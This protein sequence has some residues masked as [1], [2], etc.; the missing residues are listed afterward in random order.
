VGTPK[1]CSDVPAR[2]GRSMAC[3]QISLRVVLRLLTTDTI[4]YPLHL[5]NTLLHP[6][7]I[8]TSGRVTADAIRLRSL[9]TLPLV[10]DFLFCVGVGVGWY[11]VGSNHVANSFCQAEAGT[12]S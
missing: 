10:L 4:P 2:A 9:L 11:G 1:S 6:L 8:V 3:Q 12:G 7:K 5:W